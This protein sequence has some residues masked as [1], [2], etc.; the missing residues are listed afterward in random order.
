MPCYY[1]THIFYIII[2]Y[3]RETEAPEGLGDLMMFT[4]KLWELNPAVPTSRMV[5][6]LEDTRPQMHF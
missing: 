3:R 4:Q 1:L 2:I 5:L 6:Y